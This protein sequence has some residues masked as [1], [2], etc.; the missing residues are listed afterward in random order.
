MTKRNIANGRKNSSRSSLQLPNSA[1]RFTFPNGD[2]Y[3]GQYVYDMGNLMLMKHGSGTY[4][5][6]DSNVYR[7][8]WMKD[9]YANAKFSIQY[10]PTKAALLFLYKTN[11]A[12]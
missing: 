9:A 1:G 6:N 8:K 11:Y 3:E 2:S 5:T 12:Q 10:V 4:Y 7:G